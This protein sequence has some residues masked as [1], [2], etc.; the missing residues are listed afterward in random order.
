MQNSTGYVAIPI[1]LVAQHGIQQ[2]YE[3]QRAYHPESGCL[4]SCLR[5]DVDLVER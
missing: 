2:G 5:D 3:V 1:E 4:I